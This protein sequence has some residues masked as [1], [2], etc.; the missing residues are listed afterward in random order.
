MNT[1]TIDH[2]RK[3]AAVETRL[4]AVHPGVDIEV[5]NI[6][7]G[8]YMVAYDGLG[9]ARAIKSEYELKYNVFA[10]V[11]MFSADIEESRA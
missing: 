11:K 8:L 3:R 2:E 7:N 4:R 10:L 5:Y 6:P 9:A 1:Y